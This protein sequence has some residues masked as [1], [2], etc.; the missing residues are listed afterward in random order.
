MKILKQY[1]YKWWEL[2][3]FKASLLFFGIAIGAYWEKAFLP[4][5]AVLVAAGVVLGLYVAYISVRQQ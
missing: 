5:I 2:G 3:L 4:Y 1:T